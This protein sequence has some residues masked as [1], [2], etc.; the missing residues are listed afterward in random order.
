MKFLVYMLVG[1]AAGWLAGKLVKGGG[2]GIV[3]YIIVGVFGAVLGGVLFDVLGMS[4]GGG[5]VGDLIVATVG[6][7]VFLVLLR[8]VRRV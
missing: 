8:V 1:L 6:A 2:S 5:W 3:G 7:I 4:G